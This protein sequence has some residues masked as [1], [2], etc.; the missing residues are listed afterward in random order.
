L[1]DDDDEDG[2]VIEVNQID[3][4]I[5][6]V[7]KKFTLQNPSSFGLTFCLGENPQ[8][9]LNVTIQMA[10]YVAGEKSE[11]N[12]ER[13]W[14]RVPMVLQKEIDIADIMNG[15]K[16][17]RFDECPWIVL[18]LLARKGRSDSRYRVTLTLSN[19]LQL[20]D[21]TFLR[22]R[23]SSRTEWID[24]PH[25]GRQG[26][27]VFKDQHITHQPIIQVRGTEFEDVRQ[28]SRFEDPLGSLL[29]HETKILAIGK[30]VGVD[31][32][33]EGSLVQTDWIP[34]TEIPKMFSPSLPGI[35]EMDT[36]C[37]FDS[38]EN[39]ISSLKIFLENYRNW[40][41]ECENSD[42]EHW[43]KVRAKGLEAQLETN[44]R[45]AKE[46]AQRIEAS[47]EMLSTNREAWKAFVLMNRSIQQ[48]QMCP[49]VIERRGRS[50]FNWR[51][52]Q[53]VFILLNL[54]G[55]TRIGSTP[56]APEERDILD[57]LWFPTG[58]GK[59]EAYLG[60]IAY[61]A[62]LRRI[63]G[64]EVPATV[65]IMRYTLR[66]LT[67]QQGERAT[68]LIIAMNRVAA[69]ER[70]S[71][72][73]FTVGMW[74]GNKTSPGTKQNARKTLEMLFLGQ[75]VGGRANPAQLPSCPW[76]GSEFSEEDAE[77]NY[78]LIS[79]ESGKAFDLVC[80][81]PYC[82]IYEEPLPYSCID[83]EVYEH[84]P[85]LLIS[86]VD[87]FARMS[88]KPEAS[89]FIGKA[90]NQSPA[91]KNPPDLIILDELHLLSGPLGSIAGLWEAAL[92]SL[93][94][95]WKPKYIAAT[96][97]IRG[98]E[99]E[100]KTMFGR[101]LRIFPPPAAS[102]KDNHF[103]QEI[104][105]NEGD[106]K[107]GRI[108]LGLL[109]PMTTARMGYYG[110]M[111]SILQSSQHFSEA[112]DEVHTDPWWTVI[113]YFNSRKE[114]AAA[115]NM[116]GDQVQIKLHNIANLRREESRNT[117]FTLDELHG[118]RKPSEL[119]MAMQQLEI[120]YG[121]GNIPLDVLQTTNMFQ[122]GI[123]I[124]RLGI[125]VLTGQPYSNAEYVQA[126]GR[127]GR[128]VPG[129][130]LTTL[131][132]SKPRD[133]S[134]Y[135][136]HQTFHHRLYANVEAGS[137]TP[138]SP[139]VLD[140]VMRSIVMLLARVGNSD[141]R[142]NDKIRKLNDDQNWRDLKRQVLGF[143]EI[144]RHRIVESDRVMQVEKAVNRMMND[145][146]HFVRTR[147]Q[148]GWRAERNTPGW[149]H[150]VMTGKGGRGNILDSMRDVDIP[151][152]IGRI[153]PEGQE[154]WKFTTLPSRQ[155]F[156][157]SGPGLLWEDE[158]GG[159][160]MTLA[161]NRWEIKD[162]QRKKMEYESP[163][164]EYLG[165]SPRLTTQFDGRRVRFHRPPKDAKTEGVVTVDRM[166][167]HRVCKKGHLSTARNDQNC[168]LCDSPTS[169]VPLV[170]V[171]EHGHLEAF[172]WNSWV[173]HM[174]TCSR[175]KTSNLHHLRIERPQGST[176]I[177]AWI[178]HC[179]ECGTQ[180]RL[181]GVTSTTRGWPC[182]E[183]MPW[184]NRPNFGVRL[185]SDNE[186]DE[187]HKIQHL[188]RGN[189]GVG[190]GEQRL[191][192][193]IPPAQWHLATS[194]HPILWG[195]LGR[196][197]EASM[198]RRL[199]ME[200][201]E[202]EELIR[203]LASSDYITEDGMGLDNKRFIE[204]TIDHYRSARQRDPEE[205]IDNMRKDELK[206]FTEK[207]EEDRWIR[208]TGEFQREIVVNRYR[209]CSVPGWN[210]DSFPISDLVKIDKLRAIRILTGVTRAGGN[211]AA[212][213]WDKDDGNPWGLA[214]YENGEGIYFG[215]DMNWLKDK[216][217][218]YLDSERIRHMHHVWDRNVWPE[219]KEQMQL[220]EESDISMLVILHTMSHLMMKE[221]CNIAGYPMSSL[222]E[223]LY[224]D[225]RPGGRV[226]K[227]GVLI[228][229]TG[230]GNAGTL[231][232]LSSLAEPEIIYEVIQRAFES[233]ENCSN[234]PICG[235]H[236]P[237]RDRAS[238][239]GAA[240]HT[241]ILLPEITCELGNLL[242]D[243][244]A[245]FPEV[246]QDAV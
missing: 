79:P 205:Y 139:A 104:E 67:M 180:N 62:F 85:T 68:R 116:L 8:N 73:R 43:T 89:V 86:T 22:Y 168:P 134:F 56:I 31:W 242:L 16:A 10:H 177:S 232:G 65:A 224:I 213:I 191:S 176:N 243:R 192:L 144:V 145:L 198:R 210:D 137:T 219:V 172:R 171:C 14:T 46:T 161:L 74:I 113:S 58:G 66:L 235:C 92:Q 211:V 169:P 87:K 41:D 107:R 173:G 99:K 40:I 96:A 30:N 155:L 170:S 149:G 141:L 117:D 184:I 53:I 61:S 123:D 11:Q 50:G 90:T 239:N 203:E 227:A 185:P 103:A 20:D 138:F 244:S 7:K 200:L 4:S 42:N 78:R 179:S 125:M 215:F 140:R 175:R 150:Q 83:E 231:G 27:R 59:T 209:E 25:S 174:D 165:Q 212:P 106:D 236:K 186:D 157:R 1:D 111:A 136:N 33:Q 220:T 81:N 35:P 128:Q 26:W 189:S 48:S 6:E 28:F 130:V 197:N 151:V 80:T 160:H 218:Q 64:E 12:D 2:V 132:G 201:E 15:K 101:D 120:K 75:S 19:M 54:R 204:D 216:V 63:Q 202:P 84:P 88:S 233:A 3:E 93:M 143:L 206:G 38:K 70:L 24:W 163:L 228:F 112:H 133:L 21:E 94:G 222:T 102:I 229:V 18:S 135:E 110:P 5:E 57:L 44:L 187:R 182:G 153:P 208:S 34:S 115:H 146:H 193:E 114:M 237:R 225:K 45:T 152:P 223:R 167:Y 246:A 109:A 147:D 158:D 118:S 156:F 9:G 178:V 119:K 162:D 190:V 97:T 199:E 55:L 217:E 240:C 221:I 100:V 194:K 32:S 95:D 196:Q 195:I 148:I 166:P 207:G 188:D 234:D 36:L 230:A 122:V 69:K 37:N 77:V 71:G 39:V 127:V 131:R 17:Y 29:Y 82:D 181:M 142:A 108:H 159:T 105:I 72:V 121:D 52:F 60:L 91:R 13:V 51:P 76:C 183:H 226:A 47:L 124:D 154:A 164:L 245:L 98:A 238:S 49:L 126:S 214:E 129:L 241:C 23:F